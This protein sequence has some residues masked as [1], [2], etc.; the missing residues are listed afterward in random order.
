MPSPA[1][2]RLRLQL[3]AQ[4]DQLAERLADGD[5]S[6]LAEAHDRIAGLTLC[7]DCDTLASVFRALA[8]VLEEQ[9]GEIDRG[10]FKM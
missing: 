8:R 9:Q 6:A 1:N 10:G 2:L 3:I 7:D 4:F 5:Q